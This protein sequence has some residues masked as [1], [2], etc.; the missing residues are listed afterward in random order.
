MRYGKSVDETGGKSGA[1]RVKNNSISGTR[2]SVKFLRSL[3]NENKV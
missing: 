3:V 2:Y 1:I